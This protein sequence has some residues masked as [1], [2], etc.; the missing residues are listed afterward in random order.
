MKLRLEVMVE[1]DKAE[2]ERR[3]AGRKACGV[4]V[5]SAF[6][7]VENAICG[8]QSNLFPQVTVK[9]IKT[10]KAKKKG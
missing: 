2:Y 4:Q 9:Q 7:A 5:Y 8:I 3:N 6:D 1:V 10:K